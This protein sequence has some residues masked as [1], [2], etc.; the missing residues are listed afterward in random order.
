MPSEFRIDRFDDADKA[1]EAGVL[2]CRRALANGSHFPCAQPR[3]ESSESCSSM[4]C[5]GAD[6]LLHRPRR[7]WQRVTA[8]PTA[9]RSG[10]PPARATSSGVPCPLPMP[11]SCMAG[12]APP[13]AGTRPLASPQRRRPR[14]RG[15]AALRPATSSRKSAGLP[16]WG[17]VV[18]TMPRRFCSRSKMTSLC[19]IQ[20]MPRTVVT[21]SASMKLR[22]HTLGS[23]ALWCRYACGGHSVSMSRPGSSPPP[24]AVTKC[25]LSIG[26]SF[27]PLS[28]LCSRQQSECGSSPLVWDASFSAPHPW[29]LQ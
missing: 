9:A 5:H 29:R 7:A 14:T 26:K 2:A 12:A 3:S 8:T 1:N 16:C 24:G 18:C 23:V 21:S 22:H 6:R 13:S 25:S 19:S 15:G 28:I 17:Q 11:L 20:E 4:R 10:K 27:G